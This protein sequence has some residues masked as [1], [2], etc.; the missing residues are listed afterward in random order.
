MY[1]DNHQ[2]ISLQV[3]RVNEVM[4]DPQELMV[5]EVHLVLKVEWVTEAKTLED[6]KE[7]RDI[8]VLM[9]LMVPITQAL[10]VTAIFFI[11]ENQPLVV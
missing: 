11:D 2:I 5:D 9:A 3:L 8:Q 6:L 1:S 10:K 7:C 4:M